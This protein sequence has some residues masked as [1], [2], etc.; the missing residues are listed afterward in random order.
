MVISS[1]LLMSSR[2]SL[3]QRTYHLCE[4]CGSVVAIFG[5]VVVV[6]LAQKP[7]PIYT[8]D[9]LAATME[10]LGPNFA[11]TMQSLGTADYATTKERLSRSREQLATTVTFWRDQ[12]RDDAIG[13]VRAALQGMD[14]LDAALSTELVDS[15]AGQA[16]ATDIQAA[17]ASC[18]TVY[19]EQDPTTGEYR[20]K[21]D[22]LE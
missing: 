16:V 9:H 6:A 15:T 22:V 5:V 13:Y 8:T 18:H 10:T 21:S 20:L 17:C 7:Y 1:V 3:E 12:E 11:A 2:K 19:R 14:D 4:L